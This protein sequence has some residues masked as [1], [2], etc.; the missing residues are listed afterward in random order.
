MDI[1]TQKV[2]TNRALAVNGTH[3]LTGAAGATPDGTD[4]AAYRRGEVRL[5]KPPSFDPQ[6]PGVYAAESSALGHSVCAG[7]DLARVFSADAAFLTQYLKDQE[8]RFKETGEAIPSMGLYPRRVFFKDKKGSVVWGEDC[9]GK[10]HFDC[11]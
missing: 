9:R 3:Y 11:I 6:N 5:V 4:G 10:R 7:R 8:A 2:L 1:T